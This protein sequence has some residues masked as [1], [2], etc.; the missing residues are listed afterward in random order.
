MS[1]SGGNLGPFVGPSIASSSSVV[2][3]IPN[4]GVTNMSTWPSGDYVL[5]R[6]A[7]GVQKTIVRAGGTTAACV[8]WGSTT[9]PKDVL[10]GDSGT[11][12]RKITFQSSVNC[13][14]TLLGMSATQWVILSQ[15]PQGNTANT[16]ACFAGTS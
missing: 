3:V 14:V 4:Y 15:Y 16:T 8:V 10:F 1:A 6:P 13:A 11:S 5:D 12:H 9:Q 2:A 7:E